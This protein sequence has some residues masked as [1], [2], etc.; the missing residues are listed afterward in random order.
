M[1]RKNFLGLISVVVLQGVIKF[2]PVLF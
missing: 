2:V 1:N